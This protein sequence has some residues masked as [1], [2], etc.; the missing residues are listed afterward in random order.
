M[1]LFD[2]G[3]VVGEG[4]D[5]LSLLFPVIEPIEYLGD[6]GFFLLD[7]FEDQFFLLELL[8]AIAEQLV[9]ELAPAF[10]LLGLDD[11]IGVAAFQDLSQLLFLV[12]AH[13]LHLG[14]ELFLGNG[15]VE[16][17]FQERLVAC[18]DELLQGGPFVSRTDVLLVEEQD[19]ELG[20]YF[21]AELHDF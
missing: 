5:E 14:D 7:G 12:L 10:L 20:L 21:F 15:Q 17:Q 16:V 18:S 8:E 11:F 3:E 19:D 13:G 6:G 1:R 4:F 9:S 2:G